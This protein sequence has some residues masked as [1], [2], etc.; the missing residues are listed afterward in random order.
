MLYDFTGTFIPFLCTTLAYTGL[1]KRNF[2]GKIL[3]VLLKRERVKFNSLIAT[4]IHLFNY[5]KYLIILNK[6]LIVP[7]EYFQ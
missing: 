3:G 5:I 2:Y 6:D 4:A 7:L 1:F